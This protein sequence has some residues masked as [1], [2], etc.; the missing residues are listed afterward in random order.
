MKRLA[1]LLAALI[2][3]TTCPLQAEPISKSDR[4]KVVKE[5][6]RTRKMLEDATKGLSAAQWSFKSAP[7]RW[8]VA[9]CVEHLTLSED[10]LRGL[11]TDR[12]M[13]TSAAPEKKNAEKQAQVD[14]QVLKM[15]ADRTNR[16]QAPDGLRPTGKWADTKALMT[17]FKARR[18]KTIEY[19]KN[20]QEDLRAH[21]M[22]SPVIK[23]MDAVSW[24]LFL[25][26][27]TERH[28]KQALEVKA[29]PKFPKK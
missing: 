8:S 7:D 2:L 20:A 10:F 27:H 22:D 15:I 5:L 25:S 23:E 16:A 12:V 9:D 17:E 24:I 29:D 6:N 11:V 13:K 28:T 18:K 1:L 3:A 21:F 14:A 26:A 19:V 4:D